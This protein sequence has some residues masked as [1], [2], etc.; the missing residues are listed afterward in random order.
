MKRNGVHDNQ[1]LI[2]FIITCYNLPVWMLRDCL[3]S[4]MALSLRP[5]EREIIV[6]DDGS[7]KCFIDN[8]TE[9][10]G[11]IIIIRQRNSG[12]NAARNTGL[13]M[14]TGLYTQFV[15]GEDKLIS[16]SYEQCLDI[17]RYKTPDVVMFN[18]SCKETSL[19][20]FNIAEPVDGTT[21][22]L[23]NNPDATACG[24]IFKRKTLIGL[25]FTPGLL[26]GDEEF[27]PLLLLR[28]EKVFNTD[29]TAYFCR[30][31][32]TQI[33]ESNE[34]KHLLK[35]LNDIE[36]IIF[37]LNEISLSLP[38]KEHSALQRRVSQLTMD[39]VYDIIKFT[40]SSK[41]LDERIE[42]LKDKGLFPIPDHEYT[43]RYSVF[44]HFIKNNISRK[45]LSTILK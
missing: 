31:K 15:N 17:A 42:R 4:I 32:P 1:P 20:T 40:K 19:S 18:S 34:K 12:L 44:R 10:L 22:L 6:V 2:S 8:L 16:G 26:H 13:R 43:T 25:K 3:D 7:D 11:D 14:A 5:Y 38:L 29:I 33:T 23:H 21:L 41:Q 37:H 28:S 24:Y 35:R 39:Y 45:L 9:Y 36:Y 30:E 27:T